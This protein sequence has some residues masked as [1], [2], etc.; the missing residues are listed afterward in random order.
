MNCTNCGYNMKHEEC[1]PDGEN[2]EVQFYCPNQ[3]CAYFGARF[4]VP[5]G[6]A[7]TI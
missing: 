4:E 5:T 2:L 6:S 1:Y 3:T 7:I